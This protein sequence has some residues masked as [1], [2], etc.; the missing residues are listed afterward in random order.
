MKAEITAR[1][2]A[3][4][5]I[6]GNVLYANFC[7]WSV[8]L[9]IIHIFHHKFTITLTNSVKCYVLYYS[10]SVFIIAL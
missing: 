9:Y 2:T 4:W 5:H 3:M 10:N 8:Y 7:P 6:M 1:V